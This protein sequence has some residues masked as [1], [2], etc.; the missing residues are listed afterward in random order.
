MIRLAFL[1]Y[2]LIATTM[3]GVLVIAVL[4]MGHA[5]LWPIVGAAAAG[6]VLAVPVS[7]LVAKAIVDRTG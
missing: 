2:A 6:A 3:M 1:L 4:T 5:A 7:W